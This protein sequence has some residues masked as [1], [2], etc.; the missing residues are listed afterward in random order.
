M[1]EAGRIRVNLNSVLGRLLLVPFSWACKKMN[2]GLGQSPII[3]KIRI[4]FTVL[5]NTYS[6]YRNLKKGHD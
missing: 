5:V 6:D 4:M 2:R 1:R 3:N